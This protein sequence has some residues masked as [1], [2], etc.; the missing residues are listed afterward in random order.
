MVLLVAWGVMESLVWNVMPEEAC[1]SQFL[2]GCLWSCVSKVVFMSMGTLV[3]G[4]LLRDFITDKDANMDDRLWIYSRYGTAY[5]AMYTL[6]EITFA[7]TK[8]AQQRG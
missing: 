6:Y 1:F 7:G 8:H 2:Q 3:M 4:N 5:H